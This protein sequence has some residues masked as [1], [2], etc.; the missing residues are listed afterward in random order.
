MQWRNFSLFWILVILFNDC[1]DRYDIKTNRSS[2]SLVVS[3]MI[4][5]TLEPQY[6]KLGTTTPYQKDI[7]PLPEAVVSILDE[8][9]VREYYHD[10]GGG[11][12]RLDGIQVKGMKGKTYVLEIQ[13]PEGQQY[14]SSAESMPLPQA[15]DS[16]YFK[17]TKDKVVS[18]EGIEVDNDNVNVFLNTKLPKT[19]ESA[20][21]RWG[22]DEVYCIIPTC[23][24]GAIACPPWCYIYQEVSKLNLTVISSVD[25][26]HF[27]L[28]GILLQTRAID[29]TFLVRHYFNVTQYSMNR[30][31]YEYWKKVGL[32]TERNGS[33][34]DTPPASVAGN[35]HNINDPDEQ[36]FGYFEA[37]PQKLTRVYVDRGLVPVE[38]NSCDFDPS[39]YSLGGSRFSYCTNCYAIKG[40]TTARPDWFF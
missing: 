24:P 18:S 36:V 30:K 8:N 14:R 1:K 5:D 12:Y 32:L 26:D 21:F 40:S 29:F 15:T 23:I 38:L 17:V 6:L 9:G 27:S 2:N 4:S 3:G 39:F 35:I 34:F 10:V 19:T 22:I 11:K 28:N 25:Y 16:A 37:S 33:I 31:A 20:F 7:D 13:R